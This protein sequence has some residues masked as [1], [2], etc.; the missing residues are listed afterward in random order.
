MDSQ[1]TVIVF[2]ISQT[3][4]SNWAPS[5]FGLVFVI[6]G[7]AVFVNSTE[8]RT[9]VLAL[10]GMTFALSIAVVGQWGT[11][12]EFN[13]LQSQYA[14]AHYETVQGI[15]V[16]FEPASG[17]GNSPERFAVDGV[18]FELHAPMSTA[19]YHQTSRSGG[20]NLSGRC[21]RI[22]YTDE[23]QILWLGILSRD[24]CTQTGNGRT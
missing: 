8:A 17:A 4:F 21:V 15:V 22:A 6:I 2:D 3:S 24:Q 14:H 18:R 16:D 9:R 7:I 5:L 1:T 19:A 10:V 13:R 20:P 11:L 12:T 23:K